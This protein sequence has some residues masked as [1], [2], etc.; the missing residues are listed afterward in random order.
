MDAVK[1]AGHES[2]DP[3]LRE[4]FAT[5][6]R[7]PISL[8]CC[9]LAKQVN[10][11]GIIRLAE[12]FRLKSVRFEVEPDDALDMAGARGAGRWLD[13]QYQ[14]PISA[15]DEAKAAGSQ[16][17]CLNLNEQAASIHQVPWRFPCTIVV[18]EERLGVPEEIEAA[19]DLSA[20]IPLYG[21]MQSLNVTH[22]AVIAVWEAL[23]A[24]RGVDPSFVPARSV[25]KKL[26]GIGDL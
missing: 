9:T 18:G 12:A 4:N 11:G 14:H 24:Y 25:S 20:A 8:V 3:G 2:A 21:M 17:I 13:W 5:L 7:A 10:Q 15:I 19:C 1:A 22:A 23:N 26:M 6:P 16:V